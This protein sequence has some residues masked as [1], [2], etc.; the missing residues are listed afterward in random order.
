[1]RLRN[2]C[3]HTVFSV[4]KEKWTFFLIV[5]TVLYSESWT[6]YDA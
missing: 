3:I 2:D 5:K 4:A 1:M 6:N